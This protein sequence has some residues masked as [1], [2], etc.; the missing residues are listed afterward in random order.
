MP[1]AVP[2]GT[3]F[4]N[5]GVGPELYLESGGNRHRKLVGK[6]IGVG[7]PPLSLSLLLRERNHE[8]DDE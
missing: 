6:I 2:D 8:N 1:D 7:L 5:F 4:F 3:R